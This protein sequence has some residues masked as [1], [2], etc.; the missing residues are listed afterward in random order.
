[1][2]IQEHKDEMWAYNTVI[3]LQ[4]FS[5]FQS[6]RFRQAQLLKEFSFLIYN[7]EIYKSTLSWN[8]IFFKKKSELIMDNWWS[9]F[10]GVGDFFKKKIFNKNSDSLPILP[11]SDFSYRLIVDEV[12]QAVNFTVMFKGANHVLTEALRSNS[13]IVVFYFY[14]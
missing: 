6:L 12:A 14:I 11:W 9:K 7:S 13:G 2:M 5:V 1:M 10:G 4:S 8:H 3:T